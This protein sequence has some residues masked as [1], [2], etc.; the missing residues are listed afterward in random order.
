MQ[1]DATRIPTETT[2]E[3]EVAIVGAGPAGIT[4]A[5]ELANAGH[6]VLLVESGGDSYCPELQDLGETV[7]HDPAHVPMSLATRRQIG[8]ASNLWGGRCVPLDP[9]DFT[10]RR[11]VGDIRWPVSY[12]ELERYFSRACELCI[13][14]TPTFD[15]SRI[16]SLAG[17][18]L[19][20]G[21]EEGDIR[22]T[23]LERWSR[24]TNFG[25]AY[26]GA[27]KRSALVTLVSKI[28]CTE[29][30]C[31][32]DERRVEHLVGQTLAGGRLRI[33]A[34]RY[35]LACGGIESTR[36]LFASN[37][38][39]PGGIGNHSGHL[40]RWYMAH[41]GASIARIHLKTPPHQTLYG[42]ERDPARIY[43]RRRFTFSP[44]YLLEHD[45]PNAAMWLENPPISDP[46]HG[47]EILS[48]LYLALASPMGKHFVAEGVR[49]RK[50]GT[51]RD[52]SNG[53]H[54]RNVMRHLPRA[55]RFALTFGYERYVRPGHKVPGVFLPSP[56]NVYALYY[57]G[58]H[59]PHHASH[60]APAAERDALGVARMRTRLR[61][62][63]DDIRGAIRA[64][65]H[66]DRYLRRLG[67]GRLEYLDED[68]EE[69]FREQLLDGYHQA[70]TTRM[71]VRPQDGV[72]DPQL[73]V[74]GFDD[75][76]V[77]SSSAFVT[78]GQANSTFTI[79]V[80]AL[81]LADHIHRTLCSATA[82]R[83]SV[84]AIGA[85]A[86]DGGG[87]A[88]GWPRVV[89]ARRMV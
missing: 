74:H 57:H 31:V 73:A 79:V 49:R 13:C 41:L 70:G 44:D 77:A 46:S 67:L 33:R 43:V 39:H 6:R 27:L 9:V 69:A 53:R 51:N 61:F 29:I 50:I 20:P 56:S 80:I 59:L 7:G 19:I 54:L 63:D 45:L 4:L 2:L 25:K 86:Y 12:D 85:M 60:I 17:F 24:P 34:K 15:A 5:L 8:G 37:R 10:D 22:S 3:A 76:F 72:L 89:A 1:I 87:R 65:E 26:R 83:P 23:S 16:P 81:R 88:N 32:P 21:W 30:V 55:T 42:F 36:L 14:G 38:H 52:V 62:E 75:L 47:S 11:L 84:G 68:P 78:S 40:G 82:T 28:T 71:S 48:F 35:V 66:F 64:H 58:E 18:S